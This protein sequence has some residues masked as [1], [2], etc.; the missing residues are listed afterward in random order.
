V[1]P[2]DPLV[3]STFHTASWAR[4]G[5]ETTGKR[6]VPTLCPGTGCVLA[7]PLSGSYDYFH[8]SK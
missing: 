8:E 7:T 1:Y 5:Y 3:A 2:P 6:S 4:A